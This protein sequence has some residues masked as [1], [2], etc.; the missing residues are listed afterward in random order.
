MDRRLKSGSMRA[1]PTPIMPKS[2]AASWRGAVVV[3]NGR[4]Q[5]RHRMRVRGDG[6]KASGKKRLDTLIGAF[7]E[8]P[9]APEDLSENYKAYLDLSLGL[10]SRAAQESN[11]S[12]AGKW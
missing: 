5:V 2:C 1:S 4:D 7:D 10:K 8:R 11:P 12:G 9:D 6:L 3:H